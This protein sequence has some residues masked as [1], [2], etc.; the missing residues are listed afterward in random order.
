MSLL[1]LPRNIR[2]DIFKRVLVVRHPLYLFQDKYSAVVE[3]FGPEIPVRWL[4][5][6][7]T[8][9]QVHDEASAVLY[10]LNRFILVDTT[11][12]QVRLL[13]SFLNCIG[14]VN[15]GLL[16]HLCINF[17]VAE[18][19]GEQP[20]EILLREDGLRSLK[21]LQDNCINLKTLENFVH[22][23][24][25]TYL[26]QASHDDSQFIREALSQIDAQFKLISSLSRIIVRFYDGPPAPSLMELMQGLG[27]V[28]IVGDQGQ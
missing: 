9:R 28:I 8:N 22:R 20:G 11:P 26:R 5:L 6:L 24:N 19:V 23:E 16:S 10:G 25:S 2:D 1:S 12:Q 17:P 21:L 7:Y 15:A 3:T 14:S 13:Q 27:W 18:M 4:A